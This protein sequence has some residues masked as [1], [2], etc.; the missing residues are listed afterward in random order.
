MAWWVWVL[1]G[2]AG[3]LLVVDWLIVMGPDPR[4]WKG[5]MREYEYG[6]KR[7]RHD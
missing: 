4:T 2:G 3:A 6:K 5:G 7:G 1:I